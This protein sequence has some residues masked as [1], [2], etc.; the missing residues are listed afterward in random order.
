M[1]VPILKVISKRL[2][3]DLAGLNRLEYT[4]LRLIPYKMEDK[5]HI[6]F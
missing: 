4:I 3:Q 6:I 1:K 5:E 2:T